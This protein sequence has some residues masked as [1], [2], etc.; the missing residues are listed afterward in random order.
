[1]TKA[2]TTPQAKNAIDLKSGCLVRVHQR[3]REGDKERVQVFE[4]TILKVSSG[5]GL[6]KTFTVRKVVQNVGVEKIFPVQSPNVVKIEIVKK[7]K[8]RR[9]KLYYLRDSKRKHK[10]YEEKVSR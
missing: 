5:Q 6:Q 1:M 10:L 3:I 8:V 9:A 4:G 2:D 7:L